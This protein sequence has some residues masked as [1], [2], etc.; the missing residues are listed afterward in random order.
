METMERD[1]KEYEIGFLATEETGAQAVLKAL[2]QH[3]AEILLEGPVE[4]IA[5]AYPINRQT[6]A[7]FGYIHFRT[8]PSEM[9]GLR[10]DLDIQ[11]LVLRSLIITP[12][13]VKPKPRWETKARMKPTTSAAV[14]PEL[15]PSTAPLSNEAL[16]KKIEEILK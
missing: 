2:N 4:K 15:A 5:L 8:S 3:K 16:E 14:T 6:S 13:F 10:K 9:P 7:Y 1:T 11:S 12:P